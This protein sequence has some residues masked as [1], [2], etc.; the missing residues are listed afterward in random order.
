MGGRA[1][2]GGVVSNRVDRTLAAS[3]DR[4]G[5]FVVVVT[6][7]FLGGSGTFLA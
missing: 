5:V 7:T 6:T 3:R 2:P 1:M 4:G